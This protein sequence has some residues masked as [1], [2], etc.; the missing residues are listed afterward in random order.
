[1]ISKGKELIFITEKL[2]ILPLL[3]KT[4]AFDHNSDF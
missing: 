2:E 1:M 3:N 4:E